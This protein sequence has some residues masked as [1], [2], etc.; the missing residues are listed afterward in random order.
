MR[1]TV[2]VLSFH[3]DFAEHLEILR[4]LKVKA[5]E[6]RSL[7]DLQR[8]DSLII[9]GGESTVMSRFLM[10]SGVGAE[11]QRRVRE[12][13][14]AVY[15]TCAGAI[16][17]AK[18]IT[19]KHPPKTLGL[20]D[21][22]IERNAYGTQLQSFVADLNIAGMKKLIA[23][24]FIRAPIIK[25]IGKRVEILATYQGRPVLVRQGN[26]IAGTFHP[27]VWGETAIHQMLFL[28]HHSE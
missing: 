28:D 10:T 4:S 16:L 3:G 15:G 1:M 17:M 13:S 25:A 22:T 11:I 8:I 14:L 20:M 26:L 19:G 23:A 5:L 24:S 2:G 9:P 7:D 12:D 27:E 21:I 6:V 18:K